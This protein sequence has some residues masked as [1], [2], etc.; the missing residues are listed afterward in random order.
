MAMSYPTLS[1]PFS[2]MCTAQTVFTLVILEVA[3]QEEY[4]DIVRR[5][6]ATDGGACRA[7]PDDWYV[8]LW[9]K[10]NADVL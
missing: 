5:L 3:V 2:C 1:L 6:W 9:S 4:R 7:N 8:S 10:N